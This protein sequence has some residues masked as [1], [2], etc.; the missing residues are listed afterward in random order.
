M[1]LNRFKSQRSHEEAWADWLSEDPAPPASSAPPAPM[2][3]PRPRSA[4]T[5]NRYT[6]R[7]AASVAGQ[8]PQSAAD[9]TVTVPAANVTININVPKLRLPEAAKLKQLARPVRFRR[10]ALPYKR[11]AVGVTAAACLLTAGL[12][13]H[14][15]L[16]GRQA[17]QPAAAIGQSK[18]AGSV[19]ARTAPSFT[20]LSPA[21]KP[22]LG[23][24]A[25]GKTAYDGTKDSYSYADMLNGTPLTL[26]QQPIPAGSTAAATVAKAAAALGAREQIATKNGT[27]FLATDS[28]SGSQ[29]IVSAQKNILIL[30]QSPFRHSGDDWKAYLETLQ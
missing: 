9:P 21:G 1:D 16:A 5:A 27:A 23:Q 15:Y 29:V 13:G 28:K 20:P 3:P 22:Q 25:A 11:L 24:A 8:T 7:S 6:P 12:A 10:P 14:N 26:S 30:I 4:A 17:R 18:T 19:V 2:P